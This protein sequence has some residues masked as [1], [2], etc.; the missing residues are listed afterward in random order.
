MH[1]QQVPL[2]LDLFPCLHLGGSHE[3]SA[4]GSNLCFSSF[5]SPGQCRTGGAAR[6]PRPPGPSG[7]YQRKP[8][9][10]PTGK[11]ILLDP[12]GPV[13]LLP[14][15]LGGHEWV[16]L[17]KLRSYHLSTSSLSVQPLV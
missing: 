9:G 7:E 10:L 4:W 14:T 8:T 2:L 16:M 5:V 17:R 1:F 15:S 12:G 13:T 6:E 3:P 11:L